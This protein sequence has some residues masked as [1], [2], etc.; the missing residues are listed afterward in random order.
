MHKK[1]QDYF[2][3]IRCLLFL[4]FQRNLIKDGLFRYF[5]VLYGKNEHKIFDN[6]QD[7]KNFCKL[8]NMKNFFVSLSIPKISDLMLISCSLFMTFYKSFI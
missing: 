8:E 3:I 7:F 4:F 5:L 2:L 1:I 6:A